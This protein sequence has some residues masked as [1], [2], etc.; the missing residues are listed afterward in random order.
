MA[1]TKET[2]QERVARLKNS[3]EF[4]ETVAD[5]YRNQLVQDQLGEIAD[6]L[7]EIVKPTAPKKSTAKPKPKPSGGNDPKK[8]KE[9]A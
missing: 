2:L 4:G 3:V 8:A 7:A 1:K 9:A 5:T 6:I